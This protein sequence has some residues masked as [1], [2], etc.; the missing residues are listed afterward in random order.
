MLK[1]IVSFLV[2]LLGHPEFEYREFGSDC[3][4]AIVQIYDIDDQLYK[5][6]INTSDV[7]VSYRIYR[8]MEKIPI[9]TPPIQFIAYPEVVALQK[10]FI[11]KANGDYIKA[12]KYAIKYIYD[13]KKKQSDEAIEVLKRQFPQY[14]PERY[15]RQEEGIALYISILSDTYRKNRIERFK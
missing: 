8:V 11:K 5:T 1:L 9:S 12:S 3:L 15:Y 7:E 10:V 14:D 2:F 4:V 6:Y 13:L